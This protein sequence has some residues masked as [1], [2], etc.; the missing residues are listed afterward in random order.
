MKKRPITLTTAEDA[1]I[2]RQ[3]SEARAHIESVPGQIQI[4]GAV[5]GGGHLVYPVIEGCIEILDQARKRR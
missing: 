2:A 3:I 1:E 5:P 4:V